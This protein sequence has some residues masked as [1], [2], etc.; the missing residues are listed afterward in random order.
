MTNPGS[1]KEAYDALIYKLATLE[2][3]LGQARKLLVAP[4]KVGSWRKFWVGDRKIGITS[5]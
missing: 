3:E 5:G 1:T 4:A 2:S